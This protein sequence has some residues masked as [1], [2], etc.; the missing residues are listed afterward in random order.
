MANNVY[1]TVKPALFDPLNDADIYY[2]YRSSRASDDAA[3]SA[4]RM[5]A[6][7]G[8]MLAESKAVSEDGGSLPLP[9][10]Y[11]LRLPVDIFGKTGIYTVYIVPKAVKCTIVDV[12]TLS[13]DAGVRG[14]VVRAGEGGVSAELCKN[15]GLAGYRVEYDGGNTFRTVTTSALCVKAA[16]VVAGAGSGRYSIAAGVSSTLAFLT[17]TPSAA[18]SFKPSAVPYIGS[19]GQE[20][21]L[22]NTKFDPVCVEIEITDHDIETVSYMLE[23]EQVRNYETGRVTTYNFDGE[24]YK[25]MEYSTVKDNYSQKNI[26]EAKIDR[27]GNVDES[28][29]LA[30]VKGT[31]V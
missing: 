28:V 16:D 17:V 10:M 6:D 19:A 13:T 14:I 7:P 15:D 21:V 30:D 25:Q 31:E 18:P 22:R 12:G 26:A 20:V 4:F 24:I 2:N 8:R 11:T 5:V 9:G 29:S 27:S 23:G 1:G 3:L